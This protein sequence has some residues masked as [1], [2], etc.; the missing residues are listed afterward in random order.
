MPPAGPVLVTATSAT[1][2]GEAPGLM[3]VVVVAELLAR[4]GSTVVLVM[5][6]VSVMTVPVGTNKLGTTPNCMVPVAPGARDAMLQAATARK[7]S[8]PTAWATQPG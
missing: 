1:A 8:A 3:V 4:N 6:A 7:G 2:G 5:V